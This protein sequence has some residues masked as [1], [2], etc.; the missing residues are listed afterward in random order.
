MEKHLGLWFTVGRTL[1]ESIGLNYGS[2]N[3][4]PSLAACSLKI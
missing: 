3:T 4:S 1:T 2:Y